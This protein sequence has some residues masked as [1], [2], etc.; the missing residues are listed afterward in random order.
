MNPLMKLISVVF[1]I[2]ILLNISCRKKPLT[3]D[4]EGLVG[5][6]ECLYLDNYSPSGPHN[7]WAKDNGF[8]HTL[9]FKEDGTYQIINKE[10]G[11]KDETGRVADRAGQKLLL[12][13]CFQAK[14]YL[15]GEYEWYVNQVSLSQYLRLK[16]YV[17]F[18]ENTGKYI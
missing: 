14:K 10:G 7:I 9:V 18:R 3:G 4:F 8:T 6:W 16:G 13:N 2:C 12:K 15:S 5:Q 1:F 11:G 17:N